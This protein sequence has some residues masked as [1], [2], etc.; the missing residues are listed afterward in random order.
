[1]KTTR[2][3]DLTAGRILKY[4]PLVMGAITAAI[5]IWAAFAWRAFYVAYGTL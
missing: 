4:A 5:W 3:L 1:M 2:E